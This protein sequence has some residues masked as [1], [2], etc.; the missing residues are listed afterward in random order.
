[1]NYKMMG[2]FIGH[3][4]LVEA[5]FMVVPLIISLFHDEDIVCIGFAASLCVILA[6]ALL[7]LVLCRGSK[8]SFKAR[9]GLCAWV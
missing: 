5:V 3:I 8:R 7:L 4:L 9:K 1:M 2:R 6:V